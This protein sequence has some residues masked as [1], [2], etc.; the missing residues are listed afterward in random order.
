MNKTP[1]ETVREFT[2]DSTPLDSWGW[3]EQGS[4]IECRS[5]KSVAA[6]LNIHCRRYHS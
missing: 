5:N 6:W 3:D 1:V 4:E 2:T